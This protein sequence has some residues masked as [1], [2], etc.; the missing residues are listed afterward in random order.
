MITRR[1]L[2]RSAT[3]LAIV[4]GIGPFCAGNPCPDEDQAVLTE[5]FW[6]NLA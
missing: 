5:S 3:L 1:A 6:R 4:T 2:L